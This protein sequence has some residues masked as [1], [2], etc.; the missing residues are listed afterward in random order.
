[1]TKFSGFDDDAFI[2]LKDVQQHNSKEWFEEH[3]GVYEDRL[4]AP[5]RS[6]VE[7]L[8]VSI[9][10]ID[11]F[12]ETRSA[13]G[14]TISHLR[15][16]TR[17]SHDKSL[18]RSNMWLTF[19]RPKKNWTDA[20]A[21]FFELG[22]DWWRYG[23]GY[24][25]ASSTTMGLFRER[26]LE[27]PH[28]FQQAVRAIPKGFDVHAESYKRRIVPE[29]LPPELVPWYVKK[30]FY[31]AKCSTDMVPLSSPKLTSTLLEG[32]EPLS[33][34]YRFLVNVERMKQERGQGQANHLH[35]TLRFS[36]T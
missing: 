27:F 11:E 34:L 20:P 29:D 1:M 21:Y 36:E 14:K 30:S 7:T 24:Y 18:Y 17:F 2:F 32:F 4:L 19:K 16:D 33:G 9:K 28:E 8:G 26:L 23:L 35:P 22:P 31:I 12:I 25:S 13:I 10:Q 6:L 15:R 3:R 5:F